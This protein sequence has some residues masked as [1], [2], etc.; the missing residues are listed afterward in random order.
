MTAATN[1]VNDF[2][3]ASQQMIAQQAA[4]NT[5]Q[6]AHQ[7]QVTTLTAVAATQ[8]ENARVTREL[9]SQAARP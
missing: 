4:M 9:I 1:P 6:L 3:S 5:A 8:T 7:T 2:Q